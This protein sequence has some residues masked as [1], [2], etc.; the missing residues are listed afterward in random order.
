MDSPTF[1]A[2]VCAAVIF[3]GLSKGGFAGVGMVATPLMALVMPPVQAASVMLPILLIQDAYSVVSYRRTV[4][5][6]NI[7]ILVPGAAVGIAVGY[8]LAASLSHAAVAFAIGAISVVFALYNIV[9]KAA[10]NRPASK[11]G[12]VAGLFWGGLA[13]F[14]SM[15]AHAGSPPFHIYVMPQRLPRDLF[16]GTSVAFFA[17][18]NWIKVPPYLMLGQLTG[19]TLTLSFLLAPLALLSTWLGIKLVRMVDTERFYLIAYGLLALVGL[20]LCW[21]GAAGFI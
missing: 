7:T 20:K 21:D 3:A 19:E 1:L 4:D 17:M 10:R 16:V 9:S 6:R 11:G 13:G 8:W 5:W 14:T 12:A 2:A 18:I 15:I